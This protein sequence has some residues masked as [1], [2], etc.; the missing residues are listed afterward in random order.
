MVALARPHLSRPGRLPLRPGRGAVRPGHV[1][2]ARAMATWLPGMATYGL[3]VGV[4]AGKA[5]VP[6]L[7]GWLTGPLIYSGGAQV[8]A[9][10]LFDARAATLVVLATVLAINARLL[11]Y[12]AAAGAH[13]RDTPR[14]WRAPACYLLVDPS[15]PV[16]SDGYARVEA[17]GGDAAAMAE[18]HD[19]Y[20]GAAA[21]L[22][23]TWLLASGV[24]ML[25]ADALP[26]R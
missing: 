24:G 12:S 10:G 20:M 2:G 6:A 13:W 23:A 25:T 11:V 21:V 15:F 14:W 22:C 7:A 26:A 5:D 18:A 9:V 1:A 3:V 16:G 8:A 17:A 19:H 4:A